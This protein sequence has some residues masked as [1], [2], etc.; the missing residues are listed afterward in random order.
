[1]SEKFVKKVFIVLWFLPVMIVIVSLAVTSYYNNLISEVNFNS[2]VIEVV[3]NEFNKESV[4]ISEPPEI[5]LM[6][7]GDIMLSRHVGTKIVEADDYTLPFINIWEEL[8]IANITIGNLES[9]FYDQGLRVTQGMSFKAEPEAIAG[10]QLAGFDVLSL[11]N[12]HT[13]NQGTKGLEYTLDYL[14]KNDIETIG[15]GLD[16]DQAHTSVIIETEDMT[17]GFLGYSYADYRDVAGQKYVV[18]GLD[19]KQAKKDIIAIREEADVV[20]IVMHAGIEYVT[21]PNWQQENF[22]RGVIDAGADLVIGHHPHWPQIVEEYKDK[23]IFYSLGNFVFDQEW[24]QETKEGLILK[25]VWQEKELQR[26]ELIP[27]IIENYSTPRLAN[28][29]EKNKILSQIGLDNE[30]IFEQ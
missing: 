11:A 15:A 22:A 25:A 24:S 3:E 30:I 20:V 29:Q 6:A 27:V 12:N 26:L 28:E 18:A 16:F 1:M 21:E 23:W 5:T 9:P 4:V 10:L 14:I 8:M 13:M 2:D 7:V 19:V 17:F